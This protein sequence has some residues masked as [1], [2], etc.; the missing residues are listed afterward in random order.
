MANLKILH[1]GGMRAPREKFVD[2]AK[3]SMRLAKQV[4][5]HKNVPTTDRKYCTYSEMN[6]PVHWL[7]I[8]SFARKHV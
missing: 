3:Q 2:P 1:K 4:E 6:Q 5:I 7:S 8:V